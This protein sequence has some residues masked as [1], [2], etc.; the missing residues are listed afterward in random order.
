[1]IDGYTAFLTRFGELYPE[2]YIKIIEFPHEIIIGW[3]NTI[4]DDRK[5]LTLED[6]ERAKT[7]FDQLLAIHK[8]FKIFKT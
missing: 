3:I 4:K 8:D 2:T 6:H 1:M 5:I 7:Y